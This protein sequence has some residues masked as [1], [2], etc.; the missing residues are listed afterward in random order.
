[1][2]TDPGD[3]TP[4]RL[5]YTAFLDDAAANVRPRPRPTGTAP[6]HGAAGD[7]GT[8]DAS[9][10]DPRRRR[11]GRPPPSPPEGRECVLPGVRRSLWWRQLTAIGWWTWQVFDGAMTGTPSVVS[12]GSGVFVFVRGR[13][14]GLY[15]QRFD[16]TRW[17]GWQS[18]GGG[19]SDD[20]VAVTNGS[21]VYVFVARIRRRAV[22]APVRTAGR[23]GAAAVADSRRRSRRSPAGSRTST[24]SGVPTADSSGNGWSVVPA[25]AGSRSAGH[26]NPAVA[27]DASGCRSS[28]EAAT[29]RCTGSSS[30]AHGTDGRTSAEA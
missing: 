29:T 22:L 16:G 13:D 5:L 19:L 4:N 28:C 12:T 21:E 10:L 30:T 17:S 7:D 23:T 26:S 9:H 2:V 25:P 20:P 15:L 14:N 18:L 8:G 6:S 24:Y 11:P 1:M 3:G 27:C